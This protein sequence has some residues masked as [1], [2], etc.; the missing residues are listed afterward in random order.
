MKNRENKGENKEQVMSPQMFTTVTG[1]ILNS[2]LAADGNQDCTFVPN[3]GVPLAYN[4]I[5]TK[6]IKAHF[7]G[8]AS[9]FS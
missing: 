3:F 7:E 1:H 4:L 9:F 2:T 6:I 5:K 8:M